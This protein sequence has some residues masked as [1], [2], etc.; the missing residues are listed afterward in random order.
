MS[1][2]KELFPK[3]S[4]FDLSHEYKLSCRMG[5]LVPVL[6]EEILPGDTFRISNKMM[7]R[8]APMLAPVYHKIDATVHYFFV[9][10]RLVWD[11]WEKF[12]TG[13]D[14]GMD[15]S[16]PPYIEGN[17]TKFAASTIYDYMEIPVPHDGVTIRASALP[18]RAYNLIY[19]EWYRDQDLVPRL[20]VTKTDGADATNYSIQKR[21]WQKDYFT[22]ARPWPQKG[23]A[24]VL[25]LG[26]LA[27]VRTGDLN[28]A[29][30]ARS[31]NAMR[32]GAASGT[33]TTTGGPLYAG[34]G[35]NPGTGAGASTP[36]T[37]TSVKPVNL[38]ADLSQASAATINDLRTAFQIQTWME[39]N[40][41]GGSRY[42]ESILSHFGIQ[43]SDARLQRPEYLG[44]GKSPVIISEVL[45]TSSTDT[46]SPQ[47]NFVGHGIAGNIS[48]EIFRSFEEHGW[49]IALINIQPKTEYMQG[50]HRKFTRNTK[51]DYYFPEFANLG[52]QAILNKE[53]Y[54]GA[55][56][57][58][59]FGYQGRYD[60][61]RQ[62]KSKNNVHGAMRNSLNFW[63]MSRIFSSLPVLNA[64]FVSNDST[65]RIFAVTN[66]NVEQLYIYGVAEMEAD[67]PMPY[68]SE[69][70][71]IDHSYG[72]R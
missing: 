57:D 38:Y 3:R 65:S 7:I 49:L 46:T 19:N 21:A 30:V 2:V 63:H 8:F 24:V 55:N 68:L 29:E 28:D 61:Y 47:G 41:R 5:D 25:P 53:I 48:H 20:T 36:P 71:L 9:P 72:G 1:D 10:N 62:N 27:P 66:Q 42:I 6:C 22:S 39:R 59:I 16:V 50:L 35:T 37:I 14:N 54:A 45:Q 34:A 43:S 12:I 33:W 60:E 13:G 52:E 26:N 40:A 44:G 51:Y 32:W 31:G 17:A 69:P 4:K 70:G 11:N 58:G 18:F 15:T 23:P 56:G 67:R 64:N